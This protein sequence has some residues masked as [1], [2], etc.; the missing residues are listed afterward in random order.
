MLRIGFNF[1]DALMIVTGIMLD[2]CHIHHIMF[3]DIL[4]IS[5]KSTFLFICFTFDSL[6][7]TREL[8]TLNKT[9]YIQS[10]NIIILFL[11]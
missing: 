6:S 4:F 11:L 8:V 7:A 9:L 10:D 3:S 2:N 5:Q 1:N